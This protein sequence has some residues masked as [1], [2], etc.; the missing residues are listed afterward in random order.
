MVKKILKNRLK[1][2]Y[3]SLFP[4]S[5]H[6]ALYSKKHWDECVTVPQLHVWVEGDNEKVSED[7]NKFGPV[8]KISLLSESIKPLHKYTYVCLITGYRV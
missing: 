5:L 4:S 8:S 2:I 3:L 7:S 6:L 1:Y